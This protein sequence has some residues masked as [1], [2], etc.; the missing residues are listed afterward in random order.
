MPASVVGRCPIPIDSVVSMLKDVI[1]GSARRRV[2]MG[3]LFRGL[4]LDCHILCASAALPRPPK[5][6]LLKCEL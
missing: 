5:I 4:D 3:R 2:Y 1:L 6:K